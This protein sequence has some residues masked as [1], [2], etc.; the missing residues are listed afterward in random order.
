MRPRALASSALLN[1][2]AAAGLAFAF[3]IWGGLSIG[4]PE[5]SWR[6]R[7]QLVLA[8]WRAL[9]P[10]CLL[11]LVALVFAPARGGKGKAG[12]RPA[13]SGRGRRLLA[14]IAL[15]LCCWCYQVGVS[16]LASDPS[17]G[18]EPVDPVIY[19]GAVIAS[20]VATTYFSVAVGEKDLGRLL[21]DYPRAMLQLPHHARTHPP[22][23]IIFFRAVSWLIERVAPVREGVEAALVLLTGH[24]AESVAR[25][26][27]SAFAGYSG[28]LRG[29]RADFELWHTPGDALAAILSGWLLSLCGALS[30]LPIWALTRLRYGDHAAWWAAALFAFVPSLAL[31]GIEIDQLLLLLSALTVYLAYAGWVRQQPLLSAAAGLV[32]VGAVL[33]SFGALA[34]APFLAI[35]GA[36]GLARDR[37]ARRAARALAFC[38]SALA[39]AGAG[40]LAFLLL[41]GCSLLTL[42]STGLSAHRTGLAFP[43]SYWQWVLFDPVEFAAFLGAPLAIWALLAVFSKSEGGSATDNLLMAWLLSFLALDLSGVVRGEVGRIWLFLMFP[44]VI[45]AAGFLDRRVRLPRAGFAL[46]LAAL[47]FQTYQMKANL[48]LFSLF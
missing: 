20:P 42:I 35:W 46:L 44:P 10:A 31:F 38:G 14:L 6:H 32:F 4:L 19:S 18:R 23:P 34:L 21:R 17:L 16:S 40:V 2:P 8:P 48:Q 26:F 43:R 7:P 3:A 28:V 22:G 36:L 37:S 1:L 13:S 11:L 5:W 25:G 27:N 39:G 24:S 33:V 9:V 47:F 15:V 30:L 45:G 12:A 41:T 29:Y